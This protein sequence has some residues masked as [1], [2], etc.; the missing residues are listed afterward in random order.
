MVAFANRDAPP[1]GKRKA[2]NGRTAAVLV[3]PVRETRNSLNSSRIAGLPANAV[4]PL[5]AR[6]GQIEAMR[7]PQGRSNDEIAT[8]IKTFLSS[9]ITPRSSSRKA[10]V[11]STSST[12]NSTPN[13]TPGNSRPASMINTGEKRVDSKQM[14]A[15]NA[16]RGPISGDVVSSLHRLSNVSGTPTLSPNGS[17]PHTTL[18]S[19][20]PA[21]PEYLPMFFHASDIRANLSG[22]RGTNLTNV[23]RK[24]QSSLS[25]T[26]DDPSVEESYPDSPSPLEETQPK[27]IYANGI[28]ET[29]PGV[30]KC[31]SRATSTVSRASAN[32]NRPPHAQPQQKR[33][34]SPLKDVSIS[35]KASIS[36]PSP[37]AYISLAHNGIQ[38]QEPLSPNGSSPSQLSIGRRSSLKAASLP[39][40]RHSKASSV[41]SLSSRA[42]RRSSIAFSEIQLST[43]SSH[44]SPALEITK[45]PPEHAQKRHSA[46]ELPPAIITNP[47]SLSQSPELCPTGV[48]SP[49]RALGTD[50]KV[51]QLNALAANARRERKVLDLEIS[52]SSLLAINRT[53]EREMRKQTAE[54]RRY[55]RLTSAGRISIAPSH[56]SVSS[57]LSSLTG[58]DLPSDFDSDSNSDADPDPLDELTQPP[59][60]PS[61]PPP[62]SSASSSD[63]TTSPAARAAQQ[64]SRDADRLRHDLARHGQLLRDS[65][66]LNQSLKRCLGRT[67]ALIAEGRKALAYRVV[68]G[69]VSGGG[70][71]LTPEE[72]DGEVRGEGLESLGRE[73]GREGVGGEGRQGG[74]RLSA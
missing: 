13:G 54:L 44:S 8:P 2:V 33:A 66:R 43:T 37:R 12:P 61:S 6:G 10:R 31:I 22:L 68:V 4:S 59:F 52:N 11:D 42:N 71:V 30:L 65:Q 50:D 21:S 40:P 5:L 74:R 15:G 26:A 73:N 69:D 14:P 45:S 23:S 27:F 55:R 1:D 19:L 57:R 72:V 64:R 24:P 47:A 49:I 32:A 67:E 62:S 34:T 36:K 28:P 38:K 51:D 20:K 53:L 29:E 25:A 7:T 48:K 70:R 17:L 3:A 35:R 46:I 56:R 39:Q 18:Q 41:S 58:T 16:P 9:N 63:P 60:S